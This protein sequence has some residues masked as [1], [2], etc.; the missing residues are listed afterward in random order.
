[1]NRLLW[2]SVLITTSAT[3]ATL[4]TP[5][6]LGQLFFFDPSLSQAQDIGCFT[7]HQPA[8][9]FADTRQNAGKGMVSLGSGG[10][11]YGIRNAPPVTY[12]ANS[13]R[14]HYDADSGLY[15]G[16]QFWD[17][18]ASDLEEQITGPLFTSFEMNMPDASAV[19][20]RLEKKRTVRLQP[21]S[22]VRQR[23]LQHRRQT[24]PRLPD[25]ARL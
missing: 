21:Q 14:F 4:L 12:A 9:A 18:R 19:T 17:G 15:R 25:G 7:C 6:E 5:E 24:R 23:R 8:Y 3:A 11:H 16:G 22:P 2:A 20:A 1:M 13:P 10:M